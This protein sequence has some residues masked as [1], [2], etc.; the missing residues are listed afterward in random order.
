MGDYPWACLFSLVCLFGWLVGC[1]K[2][3]HKTASR[4]LSAKSLPCQWPYLH[5]HILQQSS[6]PLNSQLTHH[7]QSSPPLTYSSPLPN[8]LTKPATLTFLQATPPLIDH[9]ELGF[10]SFLL[11]WRRERML[12]SSRRSF[13]RPSIPL[14][15]EQMPF[16]KTSKELMRLVHFHRL[17][18]DSDHFWL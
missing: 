12:R 7:C 16:L 17:F 13:L 9:G 11:S 18:S 14:I 2:A 15:V 10:L 4:S 6:Q 8:P 5:L 3:K 1:I